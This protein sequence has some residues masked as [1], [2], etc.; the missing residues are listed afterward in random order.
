MFRF[1]VHSRERAEVGLKTSYS[2]VEV[3]PQSDDDRP[4]LFNKPNFEI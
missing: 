1:V 2:A 3:I 4:L